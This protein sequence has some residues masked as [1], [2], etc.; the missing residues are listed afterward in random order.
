M[1]SSR[2]ALCTALF[3]LASATAPVTSHAAEWRVVSF[4]VDLL[5]LDEASSAGPLQHAKLSGTG[6][7]FDDR[8][9]RDDVASGLA[10]PAT[11]G[12]WSSWRLSFSSGWGAT[13][14][15][16][17]DL[18]TMTARFDSAT[19]TMLEYY[20]GDRGAWYSVPLPFFYAVGLDEAVPITQIGEGQYQA[21]WQ[22]HSTMSNLQHDPSMPLYAVSLQ[23][24]SVSAPPPAVPE[25][26]SGL[27]ALAG[28]GAL[29]WARRRQ[30]SL[31]AA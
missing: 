31:L 1:L 29:A 9:Y 8:T 27:M 15:P 30:I 6:L 21:A 19:L 28:I 18:S 16:S 24:K 5:S 17:V 11:P 2:H 12:G 20:E 23:F 10:G 7:T 4:D 25:P 22:I 26:T 13:T 3:C 14:P